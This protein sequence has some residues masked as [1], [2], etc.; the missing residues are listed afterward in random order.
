[1]ESER[2]AL[3]AGLERSL[4]PEALRALRRAVAL[5]ERVGLEPY[6]VGGGVRDLLLGAGHVDVDLVV[7]GDAIEL[8]GAFAA[9]VRARVVRHLRFGTATVTGDG[10]RLD[11]ARARTERY[12]RPGV[13]PS[14]RPARIEDDLARRDFT[15]NAMALSLASRSAGRLVDP[16]GGQ[17]DLDAK[18]IR[19]LHDG[20]FQDDATR[21]LRA[22]RYAGRLGFKLQRRTRNLIK[23]DVT[24]LRTI[25]GTR[26]RHEFERIADEPGAAAALRLAQQLGA[27]HATHEA[28]CAGERA[29]REARGLA[30]APHRHEL[31][32]CFLLA[33]A[34]PRAATGAVQRLALTRKQAGAVR[35]LL[36][37][38]NI[39]RRLASK[40]LLPSDAVRLLEPHPAV[41]V[42][43]F[44]LLSAA[45][46]AA[47]RARRYLDEWHAVRPRLGG[48]DIEAL[49]V[50]H[51][52]KVGAALSMLRD[53]QLDGV[54]VTREDEVALV[55]KMAAERKTSRG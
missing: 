21:I 54:T 42:E 43:A 35:G 52:P 32:F 23:R 22:A 20:S 24:Y 50:P 17:R 11:F 6:L 34:P 53:A 19:V 15:I 37:L 12:L 7:E 5:A 1:M 27:L 29:L 47:D 25:S 36:A 10:F 48:R 2:E 28:L 51:G 8:A 31:V 41:S 40:T 13:L 55:G 26:L 16:Y 39:E 30:G 9:E 46:L 45:A 49:G 3:L 44:A 18:L 33:N 14:V 4:S 38:R